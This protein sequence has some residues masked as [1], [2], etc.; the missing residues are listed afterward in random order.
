MVVADMAQRLRTWVIGA[1]LIVIGVLVGYALPRSSVSPSSD[2]GT[3]TAVR[4]TVVSATSK[5]VFKP[6]KAKAAL[7]TYTLKNPTPWQATSGGVWHSS[8]QPTCLRPGSTTPV[9]ATL[10]VISVS[11]VGSAPGGPTV[12]WIEC[13]S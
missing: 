12:V 6:K 7:V 5:I 11:A 8:G 1:V 3:V 13:Y 9:K 2:A 4:G 10:G